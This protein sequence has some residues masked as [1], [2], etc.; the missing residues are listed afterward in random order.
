LVSAIIGAVT[1][2]PAGTGGIGCGSRLTEP[3]IK[4]TSAFGKSTP[5][6]LKSVARPARSSCFASSFHSAT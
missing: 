6:V 2:R 3:A 4:E 5:V 1:A